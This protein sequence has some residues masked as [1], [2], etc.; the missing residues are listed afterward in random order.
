MSMETVGVIMAILFGAVNF[1]Y[2]VH[3]NKSKDIWALVDRLNK[4]DQN[5][6]EF[7]ESIFKYVEDKCDEAVRQFGET[8]HAHAEHVRMLE[9]ELYKNFVRLDTFKENMASVANTMNERLNRIDKRFDTI[10]E[11]LRKPQ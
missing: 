10:E 5:R 4:F 1:A 8:I 3:T 6:V 9:L 7:R 11:L 2:L